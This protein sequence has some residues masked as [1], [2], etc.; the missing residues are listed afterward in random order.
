MGDEMSTQI[1]YKDKTYLLPSDC[2]L[3]VGNSCD[4]RTGRMYDG[5]KTSY[6]ITTYRTAQV[7]TYNLSFNLTTAE[8]PNLMDE[9]YKWENLVGKDITFTYCNIPFGRLMIVDFSV[10]F[11]LDGTNGIVSVALTFNLKDDAVITQKSSKI[12]SKIVAR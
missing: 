10:S 9:V 7:N 8:Y 11:G 12:E 2:S 3:S 4:T 6:G 1:K 5:S